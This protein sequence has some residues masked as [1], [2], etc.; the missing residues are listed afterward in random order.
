MFFIPTSQ[1]QRCIFFAQVETKRRIYAYR[2][3][4]FVLEAAVRGCKERAFF[5]A[6]F[7]LKSATW[8]RLHDFQNSEEQANVS[9]LC[10]AAGR[11]GS[12]LL[13]LQDKCCKERVDVL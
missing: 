9:T 10:E 4:H 13:E 8:D 6:F 2:G 1:K 7:K 5:Q 11:Y 12:D 3:A